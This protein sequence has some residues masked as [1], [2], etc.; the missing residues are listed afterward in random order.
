M[1][2]KNF[3]E[4]LITSLKKEPMSSAWFIEKDSMLMFNSCGDSVE[5]N[6]QSV[7]DGNGFM[8]VAVEGVVMIP[9]VKFVHSRVLE[10]YNEICDQ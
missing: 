9:D 7:M 1:G 3:I 10:L 2:F 4:N 5:V 8:L 6:I